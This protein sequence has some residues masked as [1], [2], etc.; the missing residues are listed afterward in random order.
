VEALFLIRW[1]PIQQIIKIRNW[2]Q[3]LILCL[4]Y[5][6]LHKHINNIQFL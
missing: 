1:K 2:I 4:I 5:L 6:Y 3:K